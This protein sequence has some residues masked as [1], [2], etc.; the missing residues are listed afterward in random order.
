[1][2]EVKIIALS[3]THNQLNKLID[4]NLIPNGDILIHSGDVSSMGEIWEIE[5]FCEEF[6]SLPHSKKLLV[7]GNHD[8]FFSKD[9]TIAREICERN[10]IVLLSDQEYV[11]DGIKFYG[12]PWTPFFC[13]WAF[14]AG[15]NQNEADYY[16]VPTMKTFTDMI[17]LDTD[18]LISHGPP[19]DILD[20]L[21]NACGTPNGQHVGCQ[22]LLDRIQVVRPDLHLF[23][24]VHSGYG[25]KHI[26]GTS[27]Y[28]LS[29]CDE[30]YT[31]SNAVAEI[32][33]VK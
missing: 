8:W 28:N 23:G 31:P 20:E 5:K 19:Y 10:G 14:N 17:P 2:A 12:M 7:P 13:N 25:Q 27:Y 3:D 18:V 29:V 16:H 15:R 22:D 4:K 11:I 26:D 1:M 6:G 32:D 21:H 9:V 30:L 33:Y 24:H